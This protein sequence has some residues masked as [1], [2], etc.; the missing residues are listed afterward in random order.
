M[1]VGNS[2]GRRVGTGVGSFV[3]GGGDD[4]NVGVS[5]RPLFP[6]VG[7]VAVE[8]GVGFGDGA[9]DNE[10]VGGDGGGRELRVVGVEVLVTGKW[11]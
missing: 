5:V 6:P 7:G 2:V 8:F 10:P 1:G 9:F 3:V 11:E 4:W